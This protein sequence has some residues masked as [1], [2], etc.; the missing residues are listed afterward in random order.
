MRKRSPV[1]TVIDTNVLF[2]GLI[3]ERGAPFA[4][5]ELWR[6]GVLRLVVSEAIE[7]EYQ[8]VL[9]RPAFTTRFAF[10]EADIAVVLGQVRDAERVII[11]PAF[12]ISIDCRDPKDQMYLTAA[13]AATVPFLISG[14]DDILACAGVRHSVRSRSYVLGNS[15]GESMNHPDASAI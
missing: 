4:I 14:D 15:S 10:T 11:D 1:R 2:S 9:A 13:M 3:S 6:A 8:R 7:T 5:L 12:D